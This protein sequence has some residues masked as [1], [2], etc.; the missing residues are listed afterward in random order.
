MFP[1]RLL[2]LSAAGAPYDFRWRRLSP[3]PFELVIVLLG[4]SLFDE[5]LQ[6]VFGANDAHATLRDVSGFEDS[7]LVALLQCLREEAE[8]PVASRLFVQGVV[9]LIARNTTEHGHCRQ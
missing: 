9:A 7:Q 8:R 6:D 5:A 2:F 3:E 4:L 1:V